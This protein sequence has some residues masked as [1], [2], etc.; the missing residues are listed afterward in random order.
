MAYAVI[1]LGRYAFPCGVSTHETRREA[2]IAAEE[3][4]KAHGFVIAKELPAHEGEETTQLVTE[5]GHESMNSYVIMRIR[6]E[7]DENHGFGDMRI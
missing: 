6:P 3:H 1:R 2:Y 5:P 4:A 7:D